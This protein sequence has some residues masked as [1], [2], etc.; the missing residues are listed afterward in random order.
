[1]NRSDVP[2]IRLHEDVPLFREALSF[3]AARTGFPAGLIEK[4]YLC[5]VLLAYLGSVDGEHVFKG[6]TCLAKV[7]GEFYRLSEDMDF[8]IPMPPEASRAERSRKIATLKHAIS[9]L[10]IGAGCFGSVTALRGANDS[11][12]YLTAVRY[13]S[14]VDG[15]DQTLQIEVSLRELRLR[16]VATGMA[17]TLLLDPVSDRPAV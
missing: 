14:R 7:Y 5:T 15:Q 1:M 4:D 8:A 2:G 11:T 10:P 3:T 9:R 16:P 13:A 12:Q 6:G 17:R